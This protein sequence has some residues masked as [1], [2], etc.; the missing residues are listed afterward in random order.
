MQQ[1]FCHT[2]QLNKKPTSGCCDGI[3]Y[4]ISSR[5]HRYAID[6][7]NVRR[8]S[9][10]K[11]RKLRSIPHRNND[12]SFKCR[13]SQSLIIQLRKQNACHFFTIGIWKGTIIFQNQ[14]IQPFSIR[15]VSRHPYRPLHQT[16][17]EKNDAIECYDFR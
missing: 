15:R 12:I 10:T 1:R 6:P 14:R 5:V 2:L 16:I 11:W 13:Q 17:D 8:D 4:K 7:H 9:E 3:E